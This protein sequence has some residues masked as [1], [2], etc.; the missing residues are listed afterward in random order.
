MSSNAD[1]DDIADYVKNAAQM[2][3]CGGTVGGKSGNA[4]DPKDIATRAEVAALLYRFIE[5]T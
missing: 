4:F 2:L 1:E 3:Y 5:A